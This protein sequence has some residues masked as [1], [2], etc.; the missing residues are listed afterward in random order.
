MRASSCRILLLIAALAIPLA[1][2]DTAPLEPLDHA[3]DDRAALGSLGLDTCDPALH[4]FTSDVT[5]RFLPL[6]VGQVQH[7]AGEEDGVAF[8]FDVTVFDGFERVGAVDT[9]VVEEREWEDG[10]LVEV[11]INYFAQTEEGTVCYFGETVDIYEDGEVVGH[12]G[13]WRADEAGHAP[14]IIMPAHPR[15]GMRYPQEWAPGIAEDRAAVLALGEGA[16]TEWGIFAKTLRTLD[17]NPL[18]GDSGEKVYALG[19]GL[20]VDGPAELVGID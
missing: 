18:D 13:S 9:R 8:T 1:A 7:F 17:F 10:E 15:V 14:G 5:N 20:V 2:C 12:D 19:V 4:T 16:E 6:P 11:S 3:V